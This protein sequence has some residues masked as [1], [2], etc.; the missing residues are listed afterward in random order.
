[1]DKKIITEYNLN[2]IQ[3]VHVSI[4]LGIGISIFFL[5]KNNLFRDLNELLLLL[6]LTVFIIG[7]ISLVISK[8]GLLIRDNELYKAY[9]VFGFLIYKQNIDIEN[10][11]IVSILKLKRAN[12]MPTVGLVSPQ[13][14]DSFYKFYAYL[15]D[16]S[17]TEKTELIGLKKLKNAELIVAFLQKHLNFDYELYSPNF[18]L[19]SKG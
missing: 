7:T 18:D 12:G 13:G 14:V 2:L 10:K 5:I 11:R 6:F 16:K 19:K 15:L 9:F 1:M 3:K 17:H 8:L 4:I